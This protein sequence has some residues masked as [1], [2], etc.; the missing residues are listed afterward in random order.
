MF[1]VDTLLRKSHT[2]YLPIRVSHLLLRNGLSTKVL[3]RAV[4]RK[5]GNLHWSPA[6]LCLFEGMLPYTS[7]E[8]WKEVM[9][10]P[11]IVL[12][13]FSEVKTL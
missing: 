3:G 8:V 4:Q 11:V 12:G 13:T 7:A 5:E 9:S 6:S 1:C 10:G 2:P